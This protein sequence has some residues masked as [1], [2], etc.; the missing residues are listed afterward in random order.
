V[1][2]HQLVMSVD[3]PCLPSAVANLSLRSS[4]TGYCDRR[5][6]RYEVCTT[7][8]VLRQNGFTGY[9][10]SRLLR[11]AH[12]RGFLDRESYVAQYI[13]LALFT[14]GATNSLG[15]DDLLAAFA[16]GVLISHRVILSA[17]SFV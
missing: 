10:F 15:N 13:A 9:S 16:A 7:L 8:G 4:D 6:H 12:Q 17:H 3:D 2:C 14:V 5:H 11:F 1:A